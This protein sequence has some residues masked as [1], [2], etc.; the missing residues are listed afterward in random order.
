MA[1]FNIRSQGIDSAT[2]F[3][4]SICWQL[5]KRYGLPYTRLPDDATQNGAFFTRLLQEASQQLDHD[6]Q[7]MIA[8][9]A[10][11]EV[12][13]RG[14]RGNILYLPSTMPENVFFIMTRR[15]VML[16]LVVQV[17]QEDYPLE[18]HQVQTEADVRLYLQRTAN[19]HL[20]AWLHTQ[21]LSPSDFIETLTQKSEGNFMYLHYVLH[22]LPALQKQNT[23]N[24]DTL[25]VGLQGY[26]HDQWVRMGMTAKPLPRVKIRVVYIL[27]EVRQPASRQLITD[28]ASTDDLPVDE[29][30][31]QEVLDEWDQFLHEQSC[32]DTI[33][34]SIYHQSF[35]DFLYNQQTTKAA[36]VSIQDINRMI[37]DDLFDAISDESAE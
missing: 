3:L 34:Y 35:R 5:I 13:L 21:H 9:D 16:P 23:L 29:L 36:G 22:V 1:H 28:F 30:M 20:K 15:D 14:H 37:A 33:C 32:Y 31:V 24:L 17:P 2:Q 18:E 19:S 27:C 26:Y 7:M 6:E 11:D 10:L 4:T 25:P 8:I 12:D